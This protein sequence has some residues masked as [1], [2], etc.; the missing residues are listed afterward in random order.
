MNHIMPSQISPSG[1]LAISKSQPARLQ[2]H[3][4]QRME[5][6]AFAAASYAI[7]IVLMFA[8]CALGSLAIR[9]PLFYSSAAAVAC[10]I[11][12][13]IFD[14]GW[15]E[16]FR[17]HFISFPYF[18]TH[19]AINIATIALAPE[20]GL[21]L[22]MVLFLICTFAS[23]RMNL[24]SL[25]VITGIVALFVAAVMIWDGNRLTMPMDTWPQRVISG[26]WIA[27]SLTRISFLGLYGAQMREQLTKRNKQ[28]AE[29][30]EK[31]D[32]L[33]THDE[34]TGALNR[35]AIMQ[36][37]EEERQ[38]M[39]RTGES[40]AVALLDIDLF[41]QVNDVHGHLVGDEVLR[42]FVRTVSDNLRFMDKIGRYG[43]EEFLVIFAVTANAEFAMNAA[44]RIRRDV[45]KFDWTS[46][47]PGTDITVS[48]GVSICGKVETADELLS[49]ADAALYKAKHDGR[50]CVRFG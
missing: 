21:L 30:F 38:R 10:G 16:R 19:C 8:L 34:L 27:F 42:C 37:L 12:Y 43:G 35:R 32:L 3:R 18:L 41:K 33:A 47:S 7:N 6:L 50:N 22:L 23:L 25:L 15:T 24:G 36:S 28:L 44:E 29:S 20:I 1:E 39:L 31:L 26:L 13:L 46:I 49:R 4:Q 14:R 9:V 48:A 11:F 2:K 17:D 45:E 40:F 5:V